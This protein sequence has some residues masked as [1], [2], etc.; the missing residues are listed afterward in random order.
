MC[1]IAMI[2]VE[3]AIMMIKNLRCIE[4]SAFHKVIKG[5]RS[6]S[7][8]ELGGELKTPYLCIGL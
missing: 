8:K 5:V 1:K 3:N 7:Q 6:V 4:N 2:F